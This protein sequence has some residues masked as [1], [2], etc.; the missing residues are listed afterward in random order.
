MSLL[1]PLLVDAA[2]MAEPSG[3]DLGGKIARTQNYFE[4]LAEGLTA[5]VRNRTDSTAGTN[6]FVERCKECAR[7][8]PAGRDGALGTADDVDLRFDRSGS[9]AT[10]PGERVKDLLAVL[11][12]A[13][14]GSP[15]VRA[16]ERRVMAIA[17][18]RAIVERRMD[19]IAQE[20]GAG[21][22]GE[23]MFLLP[24][25]R[26]LLEA[27]RLN[28]EYGA[29]DWGAFTE[30]ER[31][32]IESSIDAALESCDRRV[33]DAYKRLVAGGVDEATAARARPFVTAYLLGSRDRSAY[34]AM[35]TFASVNLAGGD[36]PLF[37][38][39]DAAA[40]LSM[41]FAAAA[42][43]AL[44]QWPI[45]DADRLRLAKII[46]EGEYEAVR[47]AGE[48]IKNL[49]PSA[50]TAR[51]QGAIDVC[52]DYL[53][54]FPSGRYAVFMGYE[55]VFFTYSLGNSAG[56]VSEAET[57]LARWPD[58]EFAAKALFMKGSALVT[59]GDVNAGAALLIDVDANFP[60]SDVV[61]GA[62]FVAGKSCAMQ[63]D[64]NKAVKCFQRIVDFHAGSAYAPKAREFIGKLVVPRT[65]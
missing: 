33:V 52:N 35:L 41:P 5:I 36:T 22:R 23:Y 59:L 34:P 44:K 13:Y 48:S 6:E 65:K 62:L 17:G 21:H 9:G 16:T 4:R 8:G 25:A 55:R 43:D 28:A 64:Y 54:R 1:V 47:T 14:P 39:D 3:G 26:D 20:A 30:E 10:E 24:S 7:Y 38:V 61:A 51:L 53:N 42:L 11:N 60:E 40:A 12:S 2:K 15:E 31:S 56:T 19:F 18:A 63:G 58:S 32:A 49:N 27:L 37:L 46:E 29:V 45:R 50:V 57:F